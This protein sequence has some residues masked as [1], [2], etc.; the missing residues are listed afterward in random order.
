MEFVVFCTLLTFSLHCLPCYSTVNC[1]P[2]TDYKKYHCAVDYESCSLA[3]TENCKG[4]FKVK[5][6]SSVK[7][8]GLLQNPVY[9]PGPPRGNLPSVI[10]FTHSVKPFP[11][12][13]VSSFY[14]VFFGSISNLLSG[15]NPP[16]STLHPAPLLHK[17]WGRA[18][19]THFETRSPGNEEAEDV[20]T[21]SYKTL[22]KQRPV[23][24]HGKK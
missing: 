18:L 21:I 13:C 11:P 10:T 6:P 8:A 1:W 19:K 15:N 4:L 14:L 16:S 2:P 17:A 9:C 5:L 3:I 7:C 20:Q 24:E 22:V 12:V 23:P